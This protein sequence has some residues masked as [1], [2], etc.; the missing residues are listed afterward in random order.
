MIA[1]IIH[2]EKFAERHGGTGNYAYA[3]AKFPTHVWEQ[4]NVRRDY[5]IQIQD[6]LAF[7]LMFSIIR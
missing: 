7:A 3:G 6:L 5:Q 4:F 2:G 1:V